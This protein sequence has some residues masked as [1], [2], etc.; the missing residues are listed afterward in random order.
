VALEIALR[1]PG[2]AATSA[3]DDLGTAPGTALLA[4]PGIAV[5]VTHQITRRWH[6]RRPHL[7]TRFRAH[8]RLP[9]TPPTTMR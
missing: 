5:G 2:R 8:Q 1:T 7:V 4:V 3:R 6:R 9:R